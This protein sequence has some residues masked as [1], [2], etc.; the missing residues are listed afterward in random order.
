LARD[1][2]PTPRR[3]PLRLSI[4]L[5]VLIFW[6]LPAG[7]GGAEW[8]RLASPQKVSDSGLWD[9]VLPRFSLKTGKAV[10]L[11]PPKG[12]AADVIIQEMRA[13]VASKTKLLMVPLMTGPDGTDYGLFPVTP[14]E[15]GGGASRLHDWLLSKIG[16]RTI[17]GFRASGKQAFKGRAGVAKAAPVDLPR[18]N[19]SK[20]EGLALK[21]CGR[22][23]VISARNKYGGIESTPSFAALKTIPDWRDR[24]L[25]FWTQPPHRAITQIKG[26]T[27]PFGPA[28]QPASI[29]LDL[30]MRDIEDIRTYVETIKPKNLGAPLRRN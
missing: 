17:N 6:T 2:G 16:Q 15:G 13:G 28:N 7:A 23:H 3:F 29:R 25:S 27:T 9:Y 21:N 14:T 8:V 24:F 22:C 20:G 4:A 30:T 10:R 26:V 11:V 19:V 12:G 18:G 5:V 1:I